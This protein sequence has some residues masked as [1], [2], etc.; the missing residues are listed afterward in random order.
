MAR[1]DGN[2]AHGRYSHVRV[3]TGYIADVDRSLHTVKVSTEHS[4]KDPED[5]QIATM[6]TTAEGDF[7]G[8]LPEVGAK[9]ILA[10]LSDNTPPVV[11]GFIADP[12]A[13]RATGDEPARLT[14]EPEG[15]P[16]NV[17]YKGNRPQ[18]N[19]GDQAF[20]TRDG[21]HLILRRGGVLEL[22]ANSI[23]KRF[24]LPIK[25][26]MRDVCENYSIDTFG[27]SLEWTTVRAEN[28][29]SGDAPCSWSMVLN[30]HAQDAKASVLVQ[31]LPV[32]APGASDKAAWKVVVA[33]EGI[34]RQTK[35]V[36]GAV[37][38]YTVTLE[39]DQIEVLASRTVTVD[40]DDSLEVSGDRTV[41]VDGDDSLTVGGDLS[42]EA[43]G[44]AVFDGDRV[45]LGGQ[46]AVEPALM[47]LAFIQWLG[48]AQWQVAGSVATIS[49]ASLAS[50]RNAL[51][52]K[53]RIK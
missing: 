47:G 35:D 27:G 50:L 37:Y 10:F 7:A 17:S 15:S 14:S 42:Y 32:L 34:D 25:N 53:V 40:G 29:P 12:F 6:Y 19:P 24:Y 2:P 44:A 30:E 41:T 11:L 26:H 20:V 3:E 28:D 8:V 18:L 13:I 48:S 16:T 5:L 51:T 39:G 36:T 38:E 43:R 46:S 22:G 45:L 33:P 23:C 21:N 52:Q 31:H 1:T 49:P 4:G 9:C